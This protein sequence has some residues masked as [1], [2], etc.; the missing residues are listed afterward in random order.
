MQIPLEQWEAICYNGFVWL[1]RLERGY[2]RCP[3]RTDFQDA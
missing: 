2:F 3:E 1:T